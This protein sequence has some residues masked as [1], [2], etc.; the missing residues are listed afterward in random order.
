VSPPQYLPYSTPQEYAT[1]T[2]PP[3]GASLGPYKS[4]GLL[5]GNTSIHPKYTFLYIMDTFL[6]R[7]CSPAGAASDPE[8]QHSS[9]SAP[10]YRAWSTITF[11]IRGTSLGT[12]FSRHDEA[13]L[14]SILPHRDDTPPAYTY[15]PPPLPMSG[16]EHGTED[17]PHTTALV[18]CLAV[19][20]VA[21]FTTAVYLSFFNHHKV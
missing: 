14:Q 1:P 12:A 7:A 6:G 13:P 3:P 4:H 2:S 17:R 9:E 19:L 5:V 20:I 18:V 10:Q 11:P 16:N 8:A 15:P 21:V